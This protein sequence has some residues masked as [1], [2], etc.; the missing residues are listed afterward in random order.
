MASE[1]G[2]SDKFLYLGQSVR[3]MPSLVAEADLVA[4]LKQAWKIAHLSY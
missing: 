3:V 1:V 4:S 2:L